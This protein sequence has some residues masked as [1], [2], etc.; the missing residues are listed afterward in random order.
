[1]KRIMAIFMLFLSGCTLKYMEEGL[2]ALR[3]QPVQTAFAVLG[4]PDNEVRLRDR[5]VYVWN[6]STSYTYQSPY[7]EATHMTM[8]A[9]Q[10]GTMFIDG[11]TSGYRTQVAQGTCQVKVVVSRYGY[12]I[13]T[14]F[15]GSAAGCGEY[16]E[17]L[18]Q[19]LYSKGNG[20]F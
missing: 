15:H 16:G 8:T 2:A 14:D 11:T 4:Y 17:R 12:I 5:T 3:N 20:L 7:E 19:Y 9:L 6:Y 18:R 10:F 1:M 13:D